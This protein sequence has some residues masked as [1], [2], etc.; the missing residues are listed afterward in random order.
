MIMGMQIFE[1]VI[2]FPLDI[3]VY[4]EVELLDHMVVLFLTFGGTSMLFSIMSASQ[5]MNK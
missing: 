1:I 3:L 5:T 4:P 2:S